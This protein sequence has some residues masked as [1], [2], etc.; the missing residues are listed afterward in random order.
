LDPRAKLTLPY[1]ARIHWRG[2]CFVDRLATLES[3]LVPRE[4]SLKIV[5]MI[6]AGE[7]FAVYIIV[8]MWPEG[9]PMAWNIQAMLSWQSRTMEMMYTDISKALKAKNINAN[10]KDYLSFFCLVNREVEVPG[11]YEPKCG[12]TP[13]LMPFQEYSSSIRH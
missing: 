12:R 11:E 3:V 2:P 5:S 8:P 4:L 6:E 9:V 10:P 1:P 13:N 7:P